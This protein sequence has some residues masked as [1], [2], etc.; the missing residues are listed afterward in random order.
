M[1][2]GS[3]FG[4]LVFMLR[5]QDVAKQG[6]AVIS[7]FVTMFLGC[8]SPGK[9]LCVN[10]KTTCVNMLHQ[11]KLFLLTVENKK[12]RVND[13]DSEASEVTW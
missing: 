8:M 3:K 5:M 11:L 13:S 12:S 9:S 7:S 2:K 10:H 1:L 6:R 4:G